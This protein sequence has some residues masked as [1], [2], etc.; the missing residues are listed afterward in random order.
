MID[1][2]EHAARTGRDGAV[3][4]DQVA[5]VEVAVGERRRA[6][7]RFLREG[8]EQRLEF[9]ECRSAQPQ[10]RVAV[11]EVF[12]EEPQFPQEE[13]RVEPG[14]KG[15]EA[16]RRRRFGEAGSFVLDPGDDVHGFVVE[17]RNVGA[18]FSPHRLQEFVPQIL[19]RNHSKFGSLFQNPGRPDAQFPVQQCGVRKR[20]GTGRVRLGHDAEHN[21]RDPPLG[22]LPAGPARGTNPEID[23]LAGLLHEW[24]DGHSGAEVRG[25]AAGSPQKDVQPRPCVRTRRLRSDRAYRHGPN[26]GDRTMV[27]AA[28]RRHP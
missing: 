8:L 22:D 11:Q 13:P 10:T 26:P 3:T 23:P 1:H 6:T 2:P 9:A 16:A 14:G 24:L 4:G 20:Q 12:G 17:H 21:G 15:S 5:R 28:S 27:I 25:E 18:S 7:G 19:E